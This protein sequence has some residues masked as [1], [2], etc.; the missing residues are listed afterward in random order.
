MKE[1]RL[2]G[3]IRKCVEY[4]TVYSQKLGKNVRRCARYAPVR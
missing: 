3:R 4:K 2:A 1:F